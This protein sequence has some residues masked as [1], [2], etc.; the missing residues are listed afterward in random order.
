MCDSIAYFANISET[1]AGRLGIVELDTPF[2]CGDMSAGNR[3]GSRCG[4]PGGLFLAVPAQNTSR[5][6]PKCGHVAAD[7]RRS[8][9]VFACVECGYSE[10]ADLVGAI[11]VLRAGH[12]RLACK[13]NG[14]VSRQQQEPS[15]RAA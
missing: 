13:V 2:L 14:E 9:A 5:T 7:N 6:C 15:E 3:A 11:N 4:L 1:L 10:N 8:Q 12:A